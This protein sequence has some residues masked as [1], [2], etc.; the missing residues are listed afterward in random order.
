MVAIDAVR[1][2]AGFVDWNTRG[3]WL[4]ITE[5]LEGLWEDRQTFLEVE[6]PDIELFEILNQMFGSLFN[7]RVDDDDEG[8]ML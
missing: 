5:T 1:L 3:L 4:D 6:P 7:K 2:F 8:G